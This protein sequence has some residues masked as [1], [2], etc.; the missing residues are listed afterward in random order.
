MNL[1]VVNPFG[2]CVMPAF[3][4]LAKY[5]PPVKVTMENWSNEA[6]GG[7]TCIEWIYRFAGT[8]LEITS[9]QPSVVNYSGAERTDASF[10]LTWDNQT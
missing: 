6:S 7:F 1:C 5:H 10:T 9:A 3:G 4:G 2:A 8:L